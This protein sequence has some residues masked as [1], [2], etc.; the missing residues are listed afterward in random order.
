MSDTGVVVSEVELKQRQSVMLVTCVITLAFLILAF[1]RA[2]TGRQTFDAPRDNV[3]FQA[4]TRFADGKGLSIPLQHTRDLPP[5]IARA[6][7][8]R[9]AANVHGKAVPI[10]FA[11]SVMLWAGLVALWR[12]LALL[13]SP[14]LTVAGGVLL[15][16]IAQ[17]LFELPK[18]STLRAQRN[19]ETWWLPFLLV[20]WFAHPGVI[21][22]GSGIYGSEIPS[23]VFVLATLL[24]FLRFWQTGRPADFRW[25]T[26]AAG[27]AVAVRYP[28]VITLL[29]PGVM[30]LVTRRV[31]LRQIAEA[32]VLLAPFAILVLA[33]NNAVYGSPTATG[34]QLVNRVLQQTL[35][36][37][38][39]GLFGFHARAAVKH[40]HFYVIQLPI[41]LEVPLLGIALGVRRMPRASALRVPLVVL[42]VSSFLTVAYYAG[43]GTFGSV[44]PVIN[45]SFVRYILPA[46]AI[47]IA[48]GVYG[49]AMRRTRA[50]QVI[51]VL[52]ILAS[53]S[54]GMAGPGG[55]INRSREIGRHKVLRALVMRH[56]QP[57]ALIAARLADRDLFPERQTLTMTYLL[58]NLDSS[59]VDTAVS[60]WDNLPSPERFADVASRIRARGIPLY[61]LYDFPQD[62]QPYGDALR[63]A[64]LQLVRRG[65]LGAPFPQLFAIT[66]VNP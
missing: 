55:I 54:L 27:A 9:D 7:T 66:P 1:P 11:G 53:V 23:M 18:G 14:A 10:D 43:L 13:L 62:I 42:L 3:G 16:R 33:F 51:F 31:R 49:F 56:T 22:N 39:S 17:E 37:P 25:M 44:S 45:A 19:F 24:Y 64:G 2:W 21:F 30:L 4:A 41:I 58:E 36:S 47:G 26:L 28:N 34:Y 29:S 50:T 52:L 46:I 20:L 5:D 38:S 12:P 61:L 6:L 15:L 63:A 59:S 8:P 40:L 32:A 60:Q 35:N 57:N 48:L 65:A